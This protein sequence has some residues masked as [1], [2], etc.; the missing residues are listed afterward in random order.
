MNRLPFGNEPIFWFL[1][2]N[3][4]WGIQSKIKSFPKGENIMLFSFQIT[5]VLICTTITLASNPSAQI[6]IGMLFVISGNCEVLVAAPSEA[7]SRHNAL[8][9]YQ[10]GSAEAQ[11]THQATHTPTQSHIYTHLTHTP[12]YTHACSNIRTQ[13][14]THTK[15]HWGPEWRWQSLLA[16]GVHSRG[17]SSRDTVVMRSLKSPCNELVCSWGSKLHVCGRVFVA[18]SRI[19]FS[20]YLLKLHIVC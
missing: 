5:F 7:Y 17:D 16:I 14:H 8:L 9:I 15:F 6:L 13:T 4:G 1:D 11:R 18:M 3:T 20:Y 19:R 2:N 12:T 10:Q